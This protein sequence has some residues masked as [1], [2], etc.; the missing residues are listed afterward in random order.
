MTFN[1]GLKV[2][3]LVLKHVTCVYAVP[4]LDK[5]DL[6]AFTTVIYHEMYNN[7]LKLCL[8]WR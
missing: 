6:A 2:I 7:A 5:A 4:R 3:C 1:P 8:H